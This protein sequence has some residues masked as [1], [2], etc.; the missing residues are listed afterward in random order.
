MTHVY[1]MNMAEEIGFY[2]L[3]LFVLGVESFATLRLFYS[4]FYQNFYTENYVKFH[5]YFL[6]FQKPKNKRKMSW[7]TLKKHL[8]NFNSCDIIDLS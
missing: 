7:E 3:D 8:T 1:T 4:D 6:V 2:T 5:S